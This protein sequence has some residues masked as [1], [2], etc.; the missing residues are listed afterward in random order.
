MNRNSTVS[1]SWHSRLP[2]RNQVGRAGAPSKNPEKRLCAAIA[3][4][5]HTWNNEKWK[6][7]AR[8]TNTTSCQG[9]W[10][11]KLKVKCQNVFKCDNR[12]A[13]CVSLVCLN[14]SSQSQ[15]NWLTKPVLILVAY[16]LRLRL[17]PSDLTTRSSYLFLS[18][19]NTII[20]MWFDNLFFTCFSV[21]KPQ[22]PS[23]LG[24]SDWPNTTN[25]SL[26]LWERNM[27][28]Y[29]DFVDDA[30]T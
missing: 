19:T 3:R 27:A 20:P 24:L 26:F 23:R 6:G 28:S 5:K 1:S 13:C 22:P 15:A 8:P 14:P 7:E 17:V 18:A 30:I 29:G 2:A 21:R 12:S 25:A 10:N 9:A 11:L 4:V 16:L